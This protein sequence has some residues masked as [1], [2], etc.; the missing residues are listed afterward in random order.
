MKGTDNGTCSHL[1]VADGYDSK[2]ST[3]F[4]H[5][6]SHSFKYELLNEEG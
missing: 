2:I 1:L 6:E 4:A 5:D 3:C